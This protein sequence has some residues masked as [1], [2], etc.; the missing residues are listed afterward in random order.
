MFV[1]V[2]RSALGA[3]I[4][5]TLNTDATNIACTQLDQT[6][7]RWVRVCVRN[8]SL[9]HVRVHT[10]VLWV[11]VDIWHRADV[12]TDASPAVP[13]ANGTKD[14]AV[15][16]WVAHNGVAYVN[17]EG[18]AAVLQVGGSMYWWR[19]GWAWGSVGVGV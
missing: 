13:V 14:S 7:L 12:Y 1:C 15:A 19:G 11:C 18:G 10:G 9:V 8:R 16:H 3:N 5:G 4:T 6:L 17:L 2:H